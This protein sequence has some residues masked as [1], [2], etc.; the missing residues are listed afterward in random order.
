MATTFEPRSADLT[1]HGLEPS[2]T[3]YWNPTTSL[4]YTHALVREEALLAEG[5]PLVV[6]TG[7]HTGRSAKDKFFVQEA[8]SEDRI[9]W[10]DIN[11]PI[12][13]E[14]F[15]GLR[16]KVVEHLNE[17][18]LYVVRDRR[19]ALSAAAQSFLN[20]LGPEPAR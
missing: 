14:G 16:E 2:G 1:E 5:G 13:E 6:D 10:G 20:L 12:A 9:A 8:E 17:R 19:R 18:D 4:L 15:G 11:Q 7:H 3:V